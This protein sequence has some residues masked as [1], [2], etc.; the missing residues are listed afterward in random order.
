MSLAVAIFGLET[1]YSAEYSDYSIFIF[2]FGKIKPIIRPIDSIILN[3]LF[4][5]KL[6]SND[7]QGVL[8]I[9]QDSKLIIFFIFNLLFLKGHLL[10]KIG[11]RGPQRA[12]GEFIFGLEI[13]YSE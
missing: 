6:E 1:E 2:S 7:T 13:E 11:L 4:S 10:E 12:E 9:L 3:I 8:L 5:I